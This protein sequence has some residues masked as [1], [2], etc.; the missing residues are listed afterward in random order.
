MTQFLFPPGRLV[1][2]SLVKTKDID[3]VTKKV[4]IDENTGQEKESIFFAVAV[5]KGPER[6]WKETAWGQIINQEALTGWPQGQHQLPGFAWKITDGDSPELNQ[7]MRAWN[8]YE[9]FPGHWIVR[10]STTLAIQVVKAKPGATPVQISPDEI[11]R[12][13]YVEV[14]GSVKANGNLSKPGVYINPEIVNFAARGE[15]IYSGPDASAVGFGQAALPAG[16]SEVPLPTA[17]FAPQP[18]PTPAPVV[19]PVQTPAPVVAPVVAPAPQPAVLAPAPAVAKT[20][21]A[22]ANGATYE[23]FVAQ[24]WTDALLVQHGYMVA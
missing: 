5:P 19:A 13:Y 6:S 14:Y 20:L 15:E 16:A 18:T 23:Q 4:K 12:G 22:K 9:G 3:N 11:K 1:Q 7:S 17:G 8:S 24:G 2:G 10:F 21:T